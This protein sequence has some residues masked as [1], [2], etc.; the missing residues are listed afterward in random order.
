MTASDAED[1]DLKRAIAISLGQER[2]MTLDAKSFGTT[3]QS[4]SRTTQ[5]TA[6]IP[7][8]DRKAM[9]E[10]RLARVARKRERSVSP[11]PFRG[12]RKAPKLETKTTVLPSGAIL[13][14]FSTVVNNDQAGRKSDAANAANQQLKAAHPRPMAREATGDSDTQKSNNNAQGIL[15]YP[16][17]VVKKTWAFGFDRTGHDVKLEEVLEPLTLRTAV[18]SA[19]Q[20]DSNWVLSKLKTPPEG[21]TKCLFIMQAKEEKQKQDMLATAEEAKS[22]LRLCFPPMDGLIHCMHSKLMLLFH[23]EK[24]RVAIPTANLLNFDW[25]ETGVMENSVFMIDLP[26]L[27]NGSKCELL[28]MTEFGKEM[29][30][31]LRLQGVEQDVR[32]GVRNFDF[33]ATQQMAFLHTAGGMHYGEDMNRTGLTGLAR[34][35]RQLNLETDDDLEIDFAASSIGSLDEGQVEK[36][37]T[38][39][40]GI[41]IV[42]REKSKTSEAKANFFKSSSSAKKSTSINEK[43]RI[44]FPTHETVT[45]SI[46]GAA[47]TIC[48]NRKYFEKPAFPRSIFRD[49]KS[50]RTG[51]LSHNKILYARGK[52]TQPDGSRNDIAWAYVG[53]AN[54]SESAWGKI[55]WDAKKKAWKIG[56][57]NWECGVILP[58]SAKRIEQAQ[59]RV[60]VKKEDDSATESESS[61]TEDEDE[62]EVQR[63]QKVPEQ[64]LGMEVFDEIVEPPFEMPGDKYNGRA[65]WYFMES[66]A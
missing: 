41:D 23:P 46:A 37:H 44:Y 4:P 45:A 48:I 27:P 22:W 2:T 6:G 40:R 12:A 66:N 52:R 51:L 58:V 15:K 5:L 60:D 62:A 20:W 63:G 11:P 38:A 28:D 50:T 54:M 18:L 33:S 25:G 42:E 35:V 8:L 64:P 13:R 7:G 31:Y 1:E 26:R 55:S 19:F 61:E 30:H 9:E 34:A 49:Y 56:C 14:S 17:G 57:R 65:P 36:L 3:M 10:E 16:H 53:S 39:A 43:I 32:D 24:L 21:R 59:E 29:L 47:G